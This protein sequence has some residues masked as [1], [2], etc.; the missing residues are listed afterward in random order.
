MRFFLL[1]GLI[2]GL[3]LAACNAQAEGGNALR[4]LALGDS[5]TIGERVAPA[6]RWPVQLAQRLREQGLDLDAPT[7]VATTGWTTAQLSAAIAAADLDDAYDLV[8]LQIGVNNQYQGRSPAEYRQEFVSLLARASA[9]AGDDPARVIVLSIPDWG[10]M[11]FAAG[12]DRA[13]IRAEIDA[14][15]A[16][17]RQAAQAAGVR[18]VDVTPI[19]RQA[20]AD[21]A[22]L[23]PDGLHPSGQMYAAWVDLVYPVALAALGAR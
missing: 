4:F 2:G 13:A 1:W 21:D 3:L 17:N 5:Y 6:Q 19:S 22:L 8:S 20:A 9:L 14:F 23:A 11:P 7:I 12:R 16:I 15:N 10:V 18:Y